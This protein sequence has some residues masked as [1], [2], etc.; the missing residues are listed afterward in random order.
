ME[1]GQRGGGVD[2]EN[3]AADWGVS[4]PDRQ[5]QDHELLTPGFSLHTLFEPDS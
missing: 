5:C 3:P 4:T 2:A 1:G